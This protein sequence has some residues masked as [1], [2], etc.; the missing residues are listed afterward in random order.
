MILKGQ[1]IVPIRRGDLLPDGI[2]LINVTTK[3]GRSLQFALSSNELGQRSFPFYTEG[4][5]TFPPLSPR[6]P[7]TVPHLSPHRRRFQA[8]RVQAQVMPE[9]KPVPCM[10]RDHPDQKL[11]PFCRKESAVTSGV[12]AKLEAP[13]S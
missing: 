3:D 1:T 8:C 11:F 2:T 5:P 7:F 9:E 6:G 10:V 12:P 13:A 4:Y